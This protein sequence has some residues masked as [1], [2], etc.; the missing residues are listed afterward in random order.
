M[1]CSVL[2]AKKFLILAVEKLWLDETFV[3][4][5]FAQKDSPKNC[6][7][8]K[9]KSKYNSPRQPNSNEKNHN[10]LKT[11]IVFPSE[12]ILPKSPAAPYIEPRLM[13]ALDNITVERK[14]CPGYDL[15][16]LICD[17]MTKDSP[18]FDCHQCL[19]RTH[20]ACAAIAADI[21]LALQKPSGRFLFLYVKSA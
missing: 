2:N 17:E 18:S 6:I 11:N 3:I 16:C 12:N 15:S 9:L 20:K 7:L 8:T 5:I 4:V 10:Q 14:D 13:A 19:H 21:V 1:A